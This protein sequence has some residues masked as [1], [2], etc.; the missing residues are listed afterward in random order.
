MKGIRRRDR[1]L[2]VYPFT[3][4]IAFTLFEA[5][6]SPLDW[7]IKDIRGTRKN[8]LTLEAAKKLIEIHQPDVLVLQDVSAPESRRTERIRRLHRLIASH[9]EGQAIEVCRYTRKQI[10]AYFKD[11]GATTRYEIAQ[12]IAAQIHAFGHRLPPVRHIWESEDSRMSL[13]DAASL[14]LTFYSEQPLEEKL[15]DE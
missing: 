7:G 11:S 5:P 1:V 6:L 3:R 12:V 15:R 2:A 9:A 4:G 14:A 13:F 8:A 10:K